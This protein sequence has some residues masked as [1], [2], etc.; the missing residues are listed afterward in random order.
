[1]TLFDPGT[2]IGISGGEPLLVNGVA[3][4]VELR[5]LVVEIA[6]R[7]GFNIDHINRYPRP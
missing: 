2:M 1:M 4:G 6:K 7:C 3:S 5:R